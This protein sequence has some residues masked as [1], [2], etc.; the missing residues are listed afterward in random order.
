MFCPECGAQQP[1]EARFCGECGTAIRS[2]VVEA[3]TQAAPASVQVVSESSVSAVPDMMKYGVLAASLVF[4]L[5][6]VGMGVYYLIG[7]DTAPEKS[8]GKL[9]LIAGLCIGVFWGLMSGGDF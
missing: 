7:K 6:G 2:G 1:D 3:P 4:P 8:V 9:W 5:I